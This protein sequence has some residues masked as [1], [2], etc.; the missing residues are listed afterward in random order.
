[1]RAVAASDEPGPD[2]AEATATSRRGGLAQRLR[3]RLIAAGAWVVVRLPETPLLRLADLVGSLAYRTSPARRERARRNLARVATWAAEQGSGSTAVRAASERREA[4]DALVESAFRHHARYWVE[5]IRAPRMTGAY[6]RE[7]VDIQDREVLDAALAEGGPIVFVGLHF[8]AIELPGFYLGQVA[9]RRAVGPMEAV[10]D[11]A[12]QDWFTRS[13]GRMGV[14]LVGLREA[15]RELVATLRAGGAV[16]I[17]A[18]RDLTGGGID[19]PLFG[20]PSPLPA[21]PALLVLETAAPTFVIAVRRTGLG[22]Y[23]ARILPLPI[24]VDGTRRE[25][26]EA[27]LAAEARAFE[28]LVVEAPEQWWAVF[29][30]IWPDLEA[31]A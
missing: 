19:T 5:L 3:V 18:D 14:R 30:P 6:I 2:A 7:R 25:R 20:H 22:R 12:L 1:M 28:R 10:A 9:G 13:R 29:H 11:P 31:A 15:R 24:P 16:G 8:G 21:G 27:F 17:V 26:V 4:L 23:A